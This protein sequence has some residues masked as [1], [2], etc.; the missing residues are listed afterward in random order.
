MKANHLINHTQ[1]YDF[2]YHIICYIADKFSE[3]NSFCWS[4]FGQ[5]QTD[6]HFVIQLIFPVWKKPAQ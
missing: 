2:N 5:F 6:H 3:F 1:I 4:M